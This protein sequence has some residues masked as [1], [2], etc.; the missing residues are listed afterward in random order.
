M[1]PEYIQKYTHIFLLTYLKIQKIEYL[2]N[3]TWR[4]YEI[5]NFFTYASQFLEVI[6][7]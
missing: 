5:K 1:Y 7:L 6:V 2:K 3:K 4:F